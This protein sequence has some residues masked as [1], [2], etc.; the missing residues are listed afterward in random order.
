M[1]VILPISD[2]D[3]PEVI[4]LVAEVLAE[5]GLEFG[6]GTKTDDDLRGLPASYASNDGAFWIGRAASGE[7]L[8]TCGVFPVAPSTF[9]LR[10]MYL[11]PA[12]RRV[13][14]GSGLLDI[15]EAWVRERGGTLI[16]LDTIEAMA[17]ACS[18]YERR[19]FVRDDVQIRAARATRGYAKRL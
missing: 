13:G 15:A 1:A 4:A 11:R 17:S 18:F 3:V 9:E 2:A 6:K 19:G 7:L 14:L 5:F 16:V 12:A 10:K 8:G